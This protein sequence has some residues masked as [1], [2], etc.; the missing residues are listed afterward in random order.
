MMKDNGK[1]TITVAEYKQFLQNQVYIDIIVNKKPLDDYI[2]LEIIKREVRRPFEVA[3][4]EPFE[5]RT[6]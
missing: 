6:A 1:I 4:A 3:G 5:Q 2:A